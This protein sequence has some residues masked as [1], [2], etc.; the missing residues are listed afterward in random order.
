ML[1]DK[2][3]MAAKRRLLAVV[4]RLG[5]RET[6]DDELASVIQHRRQPFLREVRALARS[7]AKAAPEGRH[8]QRGKDVV[9]RT[10]G[11]K[12]SR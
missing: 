12:F 10:H 7:Q 9:D 6:L 3:G 4:A 1:R 8:R 5:R 11:Q 2:Y